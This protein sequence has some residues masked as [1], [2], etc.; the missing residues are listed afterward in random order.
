MTASIGIFLRKM[1][2][3]RVASVLILLLILPLA[4]RM[5]LDSGIS[6]DEE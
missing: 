4:A 5:A 3:W 6:W 1:G 2:P